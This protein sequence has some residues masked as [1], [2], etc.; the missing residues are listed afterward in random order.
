MIIRSS[1][2]QGRV[3]MAL[4]ELIL[5]CNLSLTLPVLSY[6]LTD[7]MAKKHRLPLKEMTNF[8]GPRTTML[9]TC[10]TERLEKSIGLIPKM[11]HSV[12]LCPKG[13]LWFL[14][15]SR[16]TVPFMETWS[17]TIHGRTSNLGTG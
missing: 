5:V 14:R 8:C 12:W 4:S 3:N 16:L 1:Y 15:G 10:S 7:M 6:D 2:R 9:S 17:T 13:R 11:A